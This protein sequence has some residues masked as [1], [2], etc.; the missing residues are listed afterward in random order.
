MLSFL[1]APFVFILSIFLQAFT[2]K[3]SLG[4][5]GYSKEE[6]RFSRALGVTLLLSV[7]LFA[8]GAVPLFGILFKP[9]V[10]ILVVMLIYRIG[11]FKTLGVAVVQ[12]A[13]QVVLKWVLGLIGIGTSFLLF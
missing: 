3:A 13:I 12:V 6:N 11:F 9:L 8:V 1:L 4:F 7:L 5:F 2:L 10:W